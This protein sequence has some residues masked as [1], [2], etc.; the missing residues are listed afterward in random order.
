MRHAERVMGTVVS[1][2]VRPGDVDPA[3][4][5]RGLRRACATLHR[6]DAVFSTWKTD[7][8]MSRV[9]RGEMTVEEAPVE[10]VDVLERC[11]EARMASGGWFD[12]WAMPGGVDPTGLVKG[13][14]AQRALADLRRAG[15]RAAMVNAGGDVAVCGQPETGRPWRVGIRDPHDGTRC[16]C[17]V[18]AAAAVATSG[19]Y[20]RG[21]HVLDPYTGR[22]AAAAVVS[23]TVVGADLALADALATGLVA[24]GERGLGAVGRRPGYGA[25]IVAA[26]GSVCTTAD[27]PVA[28]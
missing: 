28:A 21:A 17:V 5:G 12:P 23:A 15:V 16:L 6:A 26:D 18:S 3:A 1:F 19:T 7:S 11:A 10:M 2:D 24:A 14:A 20:E 27:F 13:W 25:M 4:T 9:R 22:P 8:P